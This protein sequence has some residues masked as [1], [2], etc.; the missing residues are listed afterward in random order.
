ML[1]FDVPHFKLGCFVCGGWRLSRRG[2][3]C[4]LLLNLLL[5]SIADF[6]V[7]LAEI[8]EVVVSIIKVLEFNLRDLFKDIFFFQKFFIL[9]KLDVLVKKYGL[10]QGQVELGHVA[11]EV[12]FIHVAREKSVVTKNIVLARVGHVCWEIQTGNHLLGPSVFQ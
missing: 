11:P 10:I 2:F 7:E 1:H 6:C 3:A 12:K 4:R 8:F 5:D 9:K